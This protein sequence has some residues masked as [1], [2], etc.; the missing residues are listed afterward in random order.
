LRPGLE[1][2]DLFE[3]AIFAGYALVAG[4]VYAVDRAQ[5]HAEVAVYAFLYHDG[6]T[7]QEVT[8]NLVD[9]VHLAGA[10][11]IAS[12]ATNAGVVYVIVSVS[13]GHG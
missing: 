13:A 3:V 11:V 10:R 1:F 5:R 2:L 12:P 7:A 9:R 6:E 8:G 4:V